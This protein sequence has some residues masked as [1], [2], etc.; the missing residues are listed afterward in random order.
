M[1]RACALPTEALSLSTETIWS[2][3]HAQ[4]SNHTLLGM[5]PPKLPKWR[6]KHSFL[7]KMPLGSVIM[8]SSMEGQE[9]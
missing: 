6:F 5:A 3:E 1:A 2:P 8:E 4:S 9:K 7:V